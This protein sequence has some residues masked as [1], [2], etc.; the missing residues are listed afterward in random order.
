MVHFTITESCNEAVC[1]RKLGSGAQLHT[2][3]EHLTDCPK[4][5]ETLGVKDSQIVLAESSQS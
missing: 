2:N 3:N 5:L 1:G 4:C